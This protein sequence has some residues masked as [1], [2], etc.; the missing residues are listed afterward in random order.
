MKLNKLKIKKTL[1]IYQLTFRQIYKIEKKSDSFITCF[2]SSLELSLL[3]ESVDTDWVISVSGLLIGALKMECLFL[4]VS[5]SS[6]I[7]ALIRSEKSCSERFW[8]LLRVP[9]GLGYVSE[10]RRLKILLVDQTSSSMSESMDVPVELGCL[11]FGGLSAETYWNKQKRE[12]IS[13][14]ISNVKMKTVSVLN[15]AFPHIVSV[16]FGKDAE[17]CAVRDPTME[18]QNLLIDHR[19]QWQPAEYLLQQLQDPFTMHLIAK[20]RLNF[21][22]NMRLSFY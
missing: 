4:R 3:T 19:H 12:T 5:R 8:K 9:R 15:P 11:F 16:H 2:H 1:Y 18:D 21:H 7:F 17:L 22:L 14:N 10:A 13:E 20:K 6:P